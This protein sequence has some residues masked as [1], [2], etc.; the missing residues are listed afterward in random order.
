MPCYDPRDRGGHTREVVNGDDP[1]INRALREQ[2][3]KLTAIICALTNELDRRQILDS[4][5]LAA[6]EAGK[7][8]ISQHIR[9]HLGED[10]F[11]MMNMLGRLSDDELA[12][13][14]DILGAD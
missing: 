8:N 14:K 5:V 9:D 10:K 3:D 1:M 6:S 7:I 11:R 12:M 13:V 2:N 4:V